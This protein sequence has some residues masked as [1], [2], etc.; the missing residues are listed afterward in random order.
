MKL[1]SPVACCLIYLQTEIRWTFWLSLS[2]LGTDFAEV[3]LIFKLP[4]KMRWPVP[5]D[6]PISQTSWIVRLWPA[7]IA[8]R[9]FTVFSGVVLVYGRPERSSSSTDVCPSLKRLFH[10]TSF[11]LAVGIHRSLHIAFGGF[12][13]Q[14]IWDKQNLIQIIFSLNSVISVV[15]NLRIT[16]T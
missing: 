15:K 12:L 6:S 11:A 3:S 4:A 1:G 2:S 14:F 16:K 9:T 8:S 13:Q 7:R 5:Y 10:K